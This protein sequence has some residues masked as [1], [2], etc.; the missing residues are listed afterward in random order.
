MDMKPYRRNWMIG[1]FVA[2]SGI[3]VYLLSNP[4]DVKTIALYSIGAGL[5][6]AGWSG[7]VWME[8]EKP[9]PI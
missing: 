8:K 5:V 9:K 7:S 3:A 4:G 6:L 1:V 2:L